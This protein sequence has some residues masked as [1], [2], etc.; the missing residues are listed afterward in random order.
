[1]RFIAVLFS[2]I[3]HLA[4][5]QSC[6]AQGPTV[7]DSGY[8]IAG[9]KDSTVLPF[10][11]VDNRQLIKV[12]INGRGPFTFGLDTGGGN[13]VTPELAKQLGL[14]L[15]DGFQIGGAGEKRVPAWRTRVER[16][17][18][19]EITA[20]NQSFLVISLKDIQKAIGFKEFDGLLGHELFRSLTTRIDF[21]K[22]EMTFTDPEKFRYQG[23]GEIIP[24]RLSG[25]IPQIEGEIDG[26]G[27]KIVIDTGDRSSLTLFVPF[28]QENPIR[29]KY[30]DRIKAVTGWGIG[31]PI[32]SEMFRLKR[33]GFGEIV[34]TDVVA[35]LPL[36]TSGAFV[37]S[38]SIAS[39][40]SGLLKRFNVVFD[41]KR[42]RMILEKN[43][44]FNYRDDFENYILKESAGEI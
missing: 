1:M 39:I 19:G 35:R 15:T 9:E 2:A 33:L 42:N 16:V 17:E 24:F 11:L 27:G 7:S 6:S 30:P 23:E 8:R 4:L 43:R 3:A 18:V 41:Y 38:D 20:T 34:L 14:K 29:Q 32:P 44:N 21:E 40:G 22:R 12:K 10:E 31:G 36:V 28:Y 26:I 37:R 25:Q 5:L 13:L